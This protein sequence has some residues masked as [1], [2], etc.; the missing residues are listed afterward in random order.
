MSLTPLH[1]PG[2]RTSNGR[3]II[4]FKSIKYN[5]VSDEVITFFHIVASFN[6]Q[7]SEF[8]HFSCLFAHHTSSFIKLVRSLPPLHYR[9]F[10]V[11]RTP[12]A[13]W[14]EDVSHLRGT[15]L[16]C[17]PATSLRYTLLFL[18]NFT[19]PTENRPRLNFS[20]LGVKDFPPSLNIFEQI[21]FI[22]CH[23]FGNIAILQKLLFSQTAAK[24]FSQFL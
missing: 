19:H 20:C 16:S 15:I 8:V 12:A 23:N 9:A 3:T 17:F 10:P 13:A 6:R 21:L 5:S 11:L 7:P 4:K 2:I 1:E 14:E 24:L 22:C 18:W